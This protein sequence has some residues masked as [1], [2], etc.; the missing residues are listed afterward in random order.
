MVAIMIIESFLRTELFVSVFIFFAFTFSLSLLVFW[1]NELAV[2][3]SVFAYGLFSMGWSIFPLIITG[4]HYWFASRPPPELVSRTIVA[5]LTAL[6]V[7][8]AV[9]FKYSPSKYVMHYATVVIFALAISYLHGLIFI[10]DFE[11][12]KWLS[13]TVILCF[14]GLTALY[15]QDRFFV[16]VTGLMQLSYAVL[17]LLFISVFGGY[18]DWETDRK[19]V[20]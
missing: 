11:R 19:S 14:G 18:R 17:V 15:F 3:A 12:A 6:L 13:F 7:V 8:D 9:K 4:D 16:E 1:G 20:V 2:L 10:D 5:G